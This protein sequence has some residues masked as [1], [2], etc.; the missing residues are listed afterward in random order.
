MGDRVVPTRAKKGGEMETER[1]WKGL[2]SHEEQTV[3]CASCGEQY[4]KVCYSACPKCG[5]FHLEK[6]YREFQFVAKAEGRMPPWEEDGVKLT[7][8]HPESGREE[9]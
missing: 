1:T 5:D 7:L 9:R 6:M 2:R 4:C 3:T 8:P